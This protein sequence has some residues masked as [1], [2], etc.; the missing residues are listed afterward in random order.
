MRIKSRTITN[1]EW[2]DPE[3]LTLRKY[4][5]SIVDA[6]GR[7]KNFEDITEELYQAYKK[8]KAAGEEIEF[9]QLTGG[10]SGITDAKQYFDRYEEAKEDAEK[11]FD[12]GLDPEEF[13]EAERALNLLTM[14]IDEFKDAAVN[15]VTPATVEAMKKLFDVFHAGTEFLS[16]NKDEIQ[17]WGAVAVETFSTVADKIKAVKD[18]ISELAD[19]GN[20][21]PNF[22]NDW[23]GN[24]IWQRWLDQMNSDWKNTP[25]ES[26]YKPAAK[27]FFGGIGNEI[28]GGI[29]DRAAAKQEEEAVQEHIK[30]VLKAGEDLQKAHEKL[31]ADIRGEPRTQY[32]WQRLQDL[33]DE[34]KDI[35]A[36]IAN[37][38]HGYDLEL[39]QLELWKERA[40][41]QND[42]SKQ[43]LAAID[44]RYARERVRIEQETQDKL[45]DLRDE[46]TA[47]F[48]GD[49]ENR[50]IEIENFK[51]DLID[52]GMSELEATEFAQRQKA[53]AFEDRIKEITE[54]T[55]DL[56]FEA[57]HSAFEKQL[58]D[59]EDW[60]DAQ[61]EKASTAQEV[62]ALI[63]NATAKETQAF[64]NE[65]DRIKGNIQS[66]QEK[67]FEQTH[68]QRE[69]DIMRAQKQREEY[70]K[71]NP[72]DLVDQWYQNELSAIRN[73]SRGNY[74]YKKRPKLK[75]PNFDI[76]DF[77]DD[78]Q[79]KTDEAAQKYADD[80][81]VTEQLNNALKS[82]EESAD[83]LPPNLENI[84]SVSAEVAEALEQT[85]NTFGDLNDSSDLLSQYLQSAG[86]ASNDAA[87]AF[88]NAANVIEEKNHTIS[89]LAA[90]SQ[91]QQQNSTQGDTVDKVLDAV[92]TAGKMASFAGTAA[93]ATG[94]GA[95]YGI[96]LAL[97]GSAVEIIADI[98]QQA[99]NAANDSTP[100]PT[101]NNF[102]TPN[103]NQL[104]QNF[105]TAINDA[106]T[107]L[108]QMPGSLQDFQQK[109]QD[110]NLAENLPNFE[111]FNFGLDNATSALDSFS[112]SL[113]NFN[114]PAE[115]NLP[116]IDTTIFS[117]MTQQL[118]ELTQTAG[119]IAQS[120]QAIQQQSKQPPQITVSPVINVNLGGAYVFD[121][122]MKKQLTDDITS[123][124]ANAV[125]DAVNKA[126]SKSNYGY[127]N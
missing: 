63:A 67:I 114:L 79:Q 113:L 28:F 22:I 23:E 119:N 54:E 111:A 34:I 116:Q 120:A 88:E 85:K 83:K 46:A 118:S 57:T 70:L 42:L 126:T 52:A 121:N 5:A 49:L 99:R 97:G 92:Q 106:T 75:E 14:Q 18:A 36:E 104:F 124:V 8:A 84:N 48:K 56:E 15:I 64:E 7:L 44:E 21:I 29:I 91:L 30:K 39:A 3:F 108:S 43:E 117:Q 100:A 62:A 82:L 19:T 61:F 45:D 66:L 59:I 78:I 58:K 90:Q 95:A 26:I 9:L 109:L 11:I 2:D 60:K 115:N 13:H 122:S 37:F 98:I 20:E 55:A 24:A 96:P 94:A 35:N 38:K 25:F 16:E 107:A 12:A 93:T 32:G 81:G 33:R 89:Q 6:T 1:L 41:R 17:S 4:G 87:A 110:F 77:Y 103:D 10:E 112:N 40:L 47:D 69:V 101:N 80:T 74:K 31:K 102:A 68:S 86:E 123:N 73:R 53:K 71:D 127:G 51:D 27:E 50:F 125:T 105:T 72:A 76:P 65:M